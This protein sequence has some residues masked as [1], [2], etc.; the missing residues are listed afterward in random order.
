MLSPSPTR[1]QRGQIMVGT[2]D[3]INSGACNGSGMV[4]IPTVDDVEVYACTGCRNCV[5]AVPRTPAQV[6]TRR[7]SALAAVFAATDDEEW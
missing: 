6:A 1:R 3:V 2:P 4:S 7:A 5:A